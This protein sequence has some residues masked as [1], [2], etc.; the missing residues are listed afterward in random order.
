MKKVALIVAAWVTAAMCASAA[1]NISW[2]IGWGVYDYGTLSSELTQFNAG[3]GVLNPGG[4]TLFQLI[5][6]GGNA[7]NGVFVLNFRTAQKNIIYFK[8]III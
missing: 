8:N 5:L 6:W 2:S 4:S 7:N 3:T 1:V